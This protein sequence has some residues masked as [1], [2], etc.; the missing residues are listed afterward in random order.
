MNIEDVS[1]ETLGGEAAS[2]AVMMAVVFDV[3][4]TLVPVTT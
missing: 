4:R 2:R 3:D 1:R